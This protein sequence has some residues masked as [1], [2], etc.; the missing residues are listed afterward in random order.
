[1]IKTSIAARTSTSAAVV[2]SAKPLTSTTFPIALALAPLIE[3]PVSPFA[4][5][6]A[7]SAGD[8][9]CFGADG[10]PPSRALRDLSPS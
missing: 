6:N 3:S 9:L 2:P 1:M 7:L 4:S 8:R 10:A 5:L